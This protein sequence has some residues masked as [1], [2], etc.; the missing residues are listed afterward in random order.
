[1]SNADLYWVHL[2]VIKRRPKTK[3]REAQNF[4]TIIAVILKTLEKTFIHK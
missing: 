4:Q 3:S 2:L 1:M